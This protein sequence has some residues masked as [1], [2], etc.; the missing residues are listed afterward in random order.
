V[1]GAY[2]RWFMAFDEFL[3]RVLDAA[4]G[5][6]TTVLVFSDHGFGPVQQ[7]FH[8]NRWLLRR[9]YLHL[10]DASALGRPDGLLTAIDWD[11]TRALLPQRV[12][13][14][15]PQPAR[16]RAARDRRGGRGGRRAAQPRSPPTC[17]RSTTGRPARSRPGSCAGDACYRGPLAYDRPD[18][19]VRLRG[20]STLCRI[21]GRGTDLL[22]PDGPLFVAADGP[23]HYR[24]SHRRPVCSR[25]GGRAA[26]GRAV[27]RARRGIC[28]TV[29]H[30]LDLPLDATIDGRILGELLARRTPRA[31]RASRKPP[32]SPR[33]RD[34]TSTTRTK[35]PQ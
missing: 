18:L 8:V 13:R 31:R 11:R 4:A 23:E 28:P 3:G 9:G 5:T 12:R 25:R 24:G 30:L 34:R 16:P 15:A 32:T 1:T 10:R 27:Q 2:R 21:D 17:T 7:Y 29:L 22:D 19:L 20:F 35:K 26:A 14:P 33:A 6:D